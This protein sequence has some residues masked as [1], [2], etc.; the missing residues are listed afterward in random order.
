MYQIVFLC[1]L[2]AKDT[3]PLPGLI[4]TVRNSGGFTSVRDNAAARLDRGFLSFK[5]RDATSLLKY[6][7]EFI[8][9]LYKVVSFI[10]C[11]R[12]KQLQL[13]G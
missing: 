10:F 5:H 8:D 9:I 3:K 12:K 4:S 2:G 1:P 13:Y 6:N 11:L 7:N